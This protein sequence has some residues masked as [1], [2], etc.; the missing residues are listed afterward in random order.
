MGTETNLVL[1]NTDTGIA[2]DGDE[3][4]FVVNADTLS[5]VDRDALNLADDTAWYS[6]YACEIVR[7]VGVPVADLWAA[8]ERQR[9][10]GDGCAQCGT[11]YETD[12]D[13]VVCPAC[14]Y[15]PNGGES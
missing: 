11:R 7:R 3:F 4:A 8:W 14:H 12:S 15:E 2:F 10:S 6:D 1:V 5:D 13:G 9:R